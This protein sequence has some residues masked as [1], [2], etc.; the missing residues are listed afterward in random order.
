M[1]KSCFPNSNLEGQPN[2]PPTPGSDLTVGNAKYIYN[3]LLQYFRTRPD[4]LFIVITAPPLIDASN[5]ANARAFNTWLV[6]D[7]LSSNGYAQP[8]VAVFDFYNVL[9]APNNHHRFTNDQI[10]Y[11][12][13]QGGNTAFYPSGDDHPSSDGNHKATAEFVPLLNVYYHRW[14]SGGAAQ[15]PAAQPPTAQAEQAPTEAPEAAPPTAEPPAPGG[16]A[17][18]SAPNLDVIGSME[19]P[20]PAWESYRDEATSTQITCAPDNSA[21][22]SGASALHVT[23]NVAANSWATCLVHLDAPQDWSNTQGLSLFLRASQP[24]LVFEVVVYA[25]PPDQQATYERSVEAVPE[26]ASGWVELSLPWEEFHR[27][28]W[29]DQAGTPFEQRTQVNSVG[30]GFNTPPDAPNVGSIWIDDL[31][32]LGA[33][34]PPPA[35][36]TPPAVAA[37]PSPQAVQPTLPPQAPTRQ[38]TQPPESSA[39][40]TPSRTCCPATAGLPLAFVAAAWLLRWR[41]R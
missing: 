17:P 13:D 6:R 5:A 26:S 22:H 15:P 32:L 31:R 24:G 37:Q 30:L 9:T 27:V 3:D 11:V 35:A 18:A 39:S 25:G 28:S 1:F 36:A 33:G 21:A 14:L 16:V 10:E 19:Q 41:R 23:F 8:N 20:T 12:Y 2:D 7:W 34:S 4:K 29:E 40:K 38:P